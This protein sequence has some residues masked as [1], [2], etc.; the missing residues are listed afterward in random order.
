MDNFAVKLLSKD[1]VERQWA[2]KEILEKFPSRSS[3]YQIA[4]VAQGNTKALELLIPRALKNRKIFRILI[5]TLEHSI[6]PKLEKQIKVFARYSPRIALR[7]LKPLISGK[8]RTRQFAFNT[9]L[10]CSPVPPVIAFFIQLLEDEDSF[11]RTW[12][13]IYLLYHSCFHPKILSLPEREFL[14][15]FYYCPNSLNF[16]P[17]EIFVQL[18]PEVRN[19]LARIAVEKG[20]SPRWL[21]GT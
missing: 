6:S 20:I 11:I 7:F 16:I 13:A 9:L 17:L 12:S 14:E 2:Y 15:A 1:F 10:L 4:L 21:I 19:R 5:F 18:S 3:L 8:T